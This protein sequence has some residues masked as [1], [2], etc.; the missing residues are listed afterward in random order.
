MKIVFISET[1][2]IHAV[3]WASQFKNSG[4]EVHFIQGYYSPSYINYEL[5]VGDVYTPHLCLVPNR[6]SGHTFLSVPW[7]APHLYGF[8]KIFIPFFSKQYESYVAEQLNIIH[9]DII[10]VLGLHINGHNMTKILMNIWD[11]LTSPKPVLVYSSWGSD[12]DYYAIKSTHNRIE[13][14]KFLRRCQYLISECARDTTSARKFGFSGKVLPKFPAA[15]GIEINSLNKYRQSGPASK[16]KSILLKGRD[17]QG[18]RGDPI[19]RASIAIQAFAELAHELSDYEINIFQ[20]TPKLKQDALALKKQY[21]LNIKILPYGPYNSLLSVMG[22]SRIFIGLTTMDGLPLSLVEAMGL[23]ALPIYT[24]HPSLDSW[25]KH[26][27]NALL[28]KQ[29][30]VNSLIRALKL[31]LR[32]NKLVDQISENNLNLVKLRLTR[33]VTRSKAINIYKAIYEKSLNYRR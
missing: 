29:N 17:Y 14:S 12:L 30:S 6:L 27:T 5:K 25:I 15:G 24:H 8:T 22:K 20:A 28:L 26:K 4:I 33:E 3:R 1:S 21:D 2:S 13:V 18:I 10:H 16:R 32:N 31:A 9:P 7:N 11:K 23:G 19:G